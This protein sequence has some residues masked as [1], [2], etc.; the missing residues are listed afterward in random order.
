MPT[1]LADIPASVVRAFS[2]RRAEVQAQMRDRAEDSARAA[3]VA[4]LDTRRSKD[5]DVRPES[6][7]EEWGERS[8]RLGLDPA[9]LPDILGSAIL[10][11][12]PAVERELS[13]R[14]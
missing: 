11:D 5:Y 13:V 14:G 6:L 8:R 10:L 2:R 1:L 9:R 12:Q 4:A 7:A 3:Q